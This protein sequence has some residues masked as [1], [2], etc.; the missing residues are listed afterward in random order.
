MPIEYFDR[1]AT[2]AD[3]VEALRRDG[4]AIVK[5]QIEDKIAD[6]VLAELRKPFDDLGKFDE[7]EF[8]GYKTLR[9]SSILRISPTSAKLVAHPRVLEVADAIMLPH[10]LNY[11]IGSLTAIEIYPGEAD[12]VLHT[13]DSIY[14]VQIPGVQ[15]Q[16]S[17]MWALQDFTEENGATRVAIGSHRQSATRNLNRTA[18][19]IYVDSTVQAVMPKGSLLLYLGSTWHGGGGN[20]SDAPRAGLINT[21]ALGWLRQEENQY[22]NVP[23]EVA[24]QHSETIQRLMGYQ[25][26]RTLGAFQNPDGTWFENETEDSSVKT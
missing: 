26:H 22:L 19:E 23:R 20:R 9:V 11:R 18:E 7:S 25:M 3:V 24:E 13:D 16:I 21:Y 1:D 15:F 12:Q 2:S 5:N 17:A 4:A 10:C 8:N 6:A 14:P